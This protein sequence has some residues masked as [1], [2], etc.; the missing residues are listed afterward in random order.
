VAD[1]LGVGRENNLTMAATE[2]GARA[3]LGAFAVTR[4]ICGFWLA[5]SADV[6]WWAIAVGGIF[7]DDASLKYLF[8]VH[9]FVDPY[10]A[11]ILSETY[12]SLTGN[13]CFYDGA[14]AAALAE[15]TPTYSPAPCYCSAAHNFATFFAVVISI[16]FD[17]VRVPVRP[18]KKAIL[19]VTLVIYLTSLL[20]KG[21]CTFGGIVFALVLG[22]LIGA[23]N[24]FAFDAVCAPLIRAVTRRVAVQSESVKNDFP[25]GIQS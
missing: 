9:L 2:A 6:L 22:G 3:T 20:V 15:I 25:S 21:T 19:F 12:A 13:H 18:S 11:A 4:R 23:L 8:G 10:L 24:I 5:N 1:R 14:E 17:Y 7:R 16:F